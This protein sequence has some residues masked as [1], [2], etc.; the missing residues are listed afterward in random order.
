MFRT[1]LNR[2]L[3]ALAAQLKVQSM[4]SREHLLADGNLRAEV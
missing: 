4:E 1:G 3:W 2:P